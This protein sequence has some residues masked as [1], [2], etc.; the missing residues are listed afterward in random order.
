VVDLAL[1]SGSQTFFVEQVLA[2]VSLLGLEVEIP[3]LLNLRL[4]AERVS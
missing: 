1:A 4:V 2:E 3:G